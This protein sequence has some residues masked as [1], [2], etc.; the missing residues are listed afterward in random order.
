M[1]VCGGA[2]GKQN[3]TRFERLHLNH[4]IKFYSG[5]TIL[6]LKDNISSYQLFDLLITF[7]FVKHL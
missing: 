7:L 4:K 3:G 1:F 6:F 2:H 5:S